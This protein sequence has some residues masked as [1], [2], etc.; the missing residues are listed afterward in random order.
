MTEYPRNQQFAPSA[1]ESDDDTIDLG[2]LIATLWRGK[3][4]V[5]VAASVAILMGGYYAYVMAV[6]T[7]SATAAVILQTKQDSITYNGK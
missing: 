6:P 1:P 5:G 7:Y 4:I 3:W 2:A